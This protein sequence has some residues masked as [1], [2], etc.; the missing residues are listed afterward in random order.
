MLSNLFFYQLLLVG[1]L[2]LCLMLHGM[3]PA[4]RVLPGSTHPPPPWPPRKRS[5]E[6]KPCAGLTPKPHCIA[7][8]QA[9]HPPTVQPP[10]APPPHKGRFFDNQVMELPSIWH[11]VGCV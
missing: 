1:L 10:P 9:G 6:S 2:W 4:E 3:W 7:C 11:T 5:R 8:E